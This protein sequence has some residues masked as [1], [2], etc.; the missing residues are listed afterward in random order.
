MFDWIIEVNLVEEKELSESE[1]SSLLSKQDQNKIDEVERTKTNSK[2]P[3]T[4]GNEKPIDRSESSSSSSSESESESKETKKPKNSLIEQFKQ[5]YQNWKKTIISNWKK[6][7]SME[8]LEKE[9]TK[10]YPESKPGTYKHWYRTSD[11]ILARLFR[12]IRRY[13]TLNKPQPVK[14]PLKPKVEEKAP[15]TETKLAE[16]TKDLPTATGSKD[17]EKPKEVQV[18]SE[19]DPKKTS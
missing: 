15:T 10:T 4:S 17:T 2:K 16:S 13:F 18:G 6:H 8:P 14:G 9:E 3:Q 12:G 19:V 5:M 11:S 1:K 7:T